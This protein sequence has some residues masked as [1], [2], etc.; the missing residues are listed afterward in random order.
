MPQVCLG[1]RDTEITLQERQEI[2]GQAQQPQGPSTESGRS[3]VKP[4]LDPPGSSPTWSTR[5][6]WKGRRLFN[7]LNSGETRKPFTRPQHNEA[8]REGGRQKGRHCFE[9]FITLNIFHWESHPLFWDMFVLLFGFSILNTPSPFPPQSLCTCSFLCLEHI[10]LSTS[11]SFTPS[12]PQ[13]HCPFRG[14]AFPGHATGRQPPL[15]T[16]ILDPCFSSNPFLEPV[17]IYRLVSCQSPTQLSVPLEQGPFL[18]CL[19]L[20]S[21]YLPQH[22]EHRHSQ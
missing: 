4:N 8:G 13:F 6:T 20:N 10:A 11:S 22:L 5:S 14:E 9:F 18:F 7:R 3:S 2:P 17:F 16:S 15:L 1:F 12:V 21:H 19:P